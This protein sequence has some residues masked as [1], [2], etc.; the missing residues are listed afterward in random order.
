MTDR[1]ARVSPLARLRHRSVRT[2]MLGWLVAVAAIAMAL[3]GAASFVVQRNLVDARIDRSL[4]QEVAEFRTFAS[5]GLDPSTGQRFSSLERLFFVA[6]QRNVPDEHE[7]FLTLVDGRVAYYS[8]GNR[9]VQLDALP[10]VLEAAAALRPDDRALVTTV[11]TG[12][13]DVRVAAVPVTIDG[14]AASGVYVV[15]VGR[16][17][18][19][20]QALDVLR[21]YAVVAVL[22]LSLVGLIGWLVA[23]CCAPCGCC[24]TP[25]SASPRPT[26]RSGSRSPGTTTCRSWRGRSTGCSTAWRPRSPPSGRCWTTSAT[27]CGRRSPCCA[28]TSS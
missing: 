10:E 26:C 27:S 16:D 8:P 24:A 6:L 28:V 20:A 17:L 21:T 1:G 4:A 12:I 22:A 19:Q 13:G 11:D 9:A 7:A 14:S 15:G 25:R 18:E 5:T 2:R 3:A 23:G